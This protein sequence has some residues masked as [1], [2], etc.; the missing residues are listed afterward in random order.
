MWPGRGT[1]PVLWSLGT[2]DPLA[3]GRCLAGTAGAAFLGPAERRP[4]CS[5]MRR[6][7][8]VMKPRVQ[9]HEDCSRVPASEQAR[10]AGCSRTL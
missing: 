4:R 5:G 3:G 6:S 2:C 7:A 8:C 9:P 1:S 10:A